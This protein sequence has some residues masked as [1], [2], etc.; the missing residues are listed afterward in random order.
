MRAKVYYFATLLVLVQLS[1]SPCKTAAS[2]SPLHPDAVALMAAVSG[3]VLEDNP[4]SPPPNLGGEIPATD[5]FWPSFL[6]AFVMILVS[7]LGDKTFLIA[8]IMSM[9]HSRISTFAAAST[10]LALM[11]VISAA[12]GILLPNLIPRKWTLIMASVL[13]GIFGLKM[14][15]EAFQ[16]SP[17][18][19][20][21]EYDEVSHEIE[22]TEDIT[23][24]R[25]ALRSPSRHLESGGNRDSCTMAS[26]PLTRLL[27][28]A[29]A[30]RI[31]RL[32][33]PVAMQTFSL[34]FLAEWGDRSQIATIALAAAQN[35]YGVTFGAILGHC[36][37]TML[38]VLS[39]KLLSTVMSI[40]TVT[41]LG[42]V[43]FIIFAIFAIV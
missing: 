34:T 15:I 4:E 14:I 5:K 33:S 16:M 1:F 38:A 42:G 20:R 12:F 9:R 36:L 18:H 27:N 23:R 13:F 11:T 30:I 29:D 2:P 32:V 21:D 19:M 35:V 39:G 24:R 41:A 17:E 37:C 22:D 8:A 6:T 3:G 7:E 25:E 40:R 10:A 28:Y 43:S 26:S 31:G